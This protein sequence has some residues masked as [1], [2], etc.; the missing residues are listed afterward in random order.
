MSSCVDCMSFENGI[1]AQDVVSVCNAPACHEFHLSC[2]SFN[3]AGKA[4]SASTSRPTGTAT[5]SQ[6]QLHDDVTT[7]WYA[8]EMVTG[9]L[10]LHPLSQRPQPEASGQPLPQDITQPHSI[11]QQCTASSASTQAR[12][13]EQWPTPKPNEWQDIRL[14]AERACSTLDWVLSPTVTQQT[15]SESVDRLVG[16]LSQ[17]L[18]LLLPGHLT[19]LDLQMPKLFRDGLKSVLKAQLAGHVEYTGLALAMMSRLAT[20]C[21]LITTSMA[22]AGPQII[23]VF[24]EFCMQSMWL[25]CP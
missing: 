24:C 18:Q 8:A 10:R 4:R 14:I 7:A 20:D 5:V 23:S 2:T 15:P 19:D 3:L 6:K 12:A 9:L 13:S 1:P 17:L 22:V 16:Q 25:P 21:S 11:E